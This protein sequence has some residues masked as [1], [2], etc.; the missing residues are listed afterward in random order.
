MTEADSAV[1]EAPKDDP[2][3][4]TEP[5]PENEAEALEEAEQA[6]N[7][8]VAQTPQT[9]IEARRRGNF[10]KGQMD[11][12]RAT[13]AKDANPGELAM[14]L[15]ICARYQLD[16]FAK[17]IWCARMGGGGGGITIMVSRDGLLALAN[18][19]PDFAGM[20]GDVVR[21]NDTFHKIHTFEGVAIT[22]EVTEAS[23][24]KRGKVVGAWAVV[25]R[26][27]R[28][29]TYFFAQLEQYMGHA[30]S[31][32]GK[33]VDAMILKVAES[34][35]LRKA[36]SISGVVGEDEVA[37]K[38]PAALT[39]S[40]SVVSPEI[41]WPE[42]EE[43]AAELKTAFEMLGYTKAKIRL[44]VNGKDDEQLRA[45]LAELHT[46]ADQGEAVTGEVVDG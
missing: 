30:K 18:R 8:L 43:L 4:A 5:A 3:P 17:Q 40:G 16:P 33:Q 44:K 20:D 41:E 37:H 38:K 1:A 29:P 6:A 39:A 45:L 28:R 27:S 36:F 19:N 2:E 12:I 32:W 42:D 11:L 21:E 14:F 34:M 24:E 9:G 10:D 15:E 31:P 7:E 23:V 46:E 22:H 35:A 25:Y 13:V 26:E